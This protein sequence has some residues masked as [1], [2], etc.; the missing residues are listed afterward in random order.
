MFCFQ[1]RT[2]FS[3]INDFLQ[4]IIDTDKEAK[5]L[6]VAFCE[7]KDC[8]TE[9]HRSCDKLKDSFVKITGQELFP[10]ETRCPCWEAKELE[11]VTAE[12]VSGSI[13]CSGDE[14]KWASA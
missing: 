7:A 3:G 5:G 4:Y 11:S 10:C 2:E 14:M 8:D 12:N 6:C 1:G 13:S 9:Y